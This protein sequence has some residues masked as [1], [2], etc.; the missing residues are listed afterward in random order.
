MI[1]NTI[2]DI[3]CSKFKEN[4]KNSTRLLKTWNAF[5]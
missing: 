5:G 1:R 2:R 3:D 4:S